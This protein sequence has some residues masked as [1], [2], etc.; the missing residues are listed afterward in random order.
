QRILERERRARLVLAEDVHEVERMGGRLDVREIELRHL[1]DG[2]EDRAQLLLEALDLLVGQRQ[3]REPR[4]MQ[5]LFS[6]DR[7]VP[8]PSN[9]EA[10]FRGPLT[11][12]PK[13]KSSDRDDVRRLQALLA[14]HD[15][16]LDLL[17]LGQRLVPVHRDRREVDE[18]VLP[19]LA[20]DEPI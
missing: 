8:N 15:L 1:A 4:D 2:I 9:K 11:T 18:D 5:Y 19:L 16:E 12:V 10:P 7:H 6:A 3:P 17:T 13:G 20:L 14:L